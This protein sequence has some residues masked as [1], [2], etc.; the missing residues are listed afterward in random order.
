ML[1]TGKGAWEHGAV[2]LSHAALQDSWVCKALLDNRL[3]LCLQVMRLALREIRLLKAAQHKNVVQLLE[4]F[5]S[6]SG[7]VYIVMVGDSTSVRRRGI[8][9][10]CALVGP[11]CPTSISTL[12]SFAWPDHLYSSWVWCSRVSMSATW[13]TESTL[14]FDLQEYVERTLTQD[15]RKYTR[16]FPP[17]LVKMVTWQLLQ[18]ISFLHRNRVGGGGGVNR[19]DVPFPGRATPS[20]AMCPMAMCH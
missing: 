10:T 16:G 1:G 12:R 9:Q 17:V 8:R 19:R 13:S 4:A 7:R 6:K 18:A 14:C 20:E 2:E 15:L 5:R 11:V 3:L